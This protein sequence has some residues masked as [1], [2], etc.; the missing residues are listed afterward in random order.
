M[1]A[2]P[3][4]P[5]RRRGRRRSIRVFRTYRQP[6]LWNTLRFHIRSI[7]FIVTFAELDMRTSTS[8]RNIIIRTVATLTGDIAVATAIAG[9]SLW[10]IEAAA[11]GWFLS[12]LVWLIGALV[13]LALSQFVIHP[14]VAVLLSD[15][16]LDQAV[17]SLVGLGDVL[18][19]VGADV[20]SSLMSALRSSSTL[21]RFRPA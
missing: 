21:R 18:T 1:P 8:R 9:A 7:P 3:V 15:R 14:A 20:G 4:R 11:L 19:Q 2:R 12:F 10:L 5:Y 17:D 13:A 16:K 6:S